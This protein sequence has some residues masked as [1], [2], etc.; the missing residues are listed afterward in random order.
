MIKPVSIN[1]SIYFGC[2]AAFVVHQT[3]NTTNATNRSKS[4]SARYH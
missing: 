1:E 2:F 3:L 4:L